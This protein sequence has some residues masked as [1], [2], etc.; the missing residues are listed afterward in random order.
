MI[1]E[2]NDEEIL[3]FL[4]NSDFEGDFK[5]EEYRYLLHKWKYFYRIL[6]GRYE[7]SRVNHEGEIRQL[8]SDKES[9]NKSLFDIQVESAQKEDII[10]SMKSRKLTLKERWSGKIILNENENK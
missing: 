1:S 10:G 3:D 6:N 4:M 9:L 7:L 8:I 5:P 2:L